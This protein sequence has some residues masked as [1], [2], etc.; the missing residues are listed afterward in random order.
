MTWTSVEML[1]WIVAGLAAAWLP[2]RRW[3]VP[4]VSALSAAFL[5]WHAPLSCA[6][7]ACFAVGV[8]LA[9]ARSSSPARPLAAV[10]VVTATMLPI[11]VAISRPI[12]SYNEIQ[13]RAFGL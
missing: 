12:S 3:Q 13:L 9:L 2:P 1:G 7:L 5:V 4:A 11:I 6:L 8:H 10:A